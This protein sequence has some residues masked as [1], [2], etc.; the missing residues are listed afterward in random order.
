MIK[1]FRN[2][3]EYNE[4]LQWQSFSTKQKAEKFAQIFGHD[5]L[6]IVIAVDAY[7]PQG[8]EWADGYVFVHP[9]AQELLNFIIT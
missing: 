1:R 6:P 4:W 2:K 9:K 7:T 3:E 8:G 5:V